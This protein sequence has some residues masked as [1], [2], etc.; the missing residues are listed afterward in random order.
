M[1]QFLCVL[2]D[3]QDLTQLDHIQLQLEEYEN[4][5]P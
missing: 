2:T 5:N 3:N 4:I 1:A